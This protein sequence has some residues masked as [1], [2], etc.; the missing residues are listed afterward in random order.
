MTTYDAI[1]TWKLDIYCPMSDG[2]GVRIEVDEN[3]SVA[4]SHLV[5]VPP[6][7]N[8]ENSLPVFS[9]RWKE[10]YLCQTD[11]LTMAAEFFDECARMCRLAER[12]IERHKEGDGVGT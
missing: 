7:K 3:E 12:Q 9:P 5:Y 11:D 4:F 6:K 8:P 2:D 10:K 1:M